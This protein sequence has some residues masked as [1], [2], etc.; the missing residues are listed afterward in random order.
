MHALLTQDNR[1]IPQQNNE[2]RPR[3]QKFTKKQ[4]TTNKSINKSNNSAKKSTGF[5]QTTR[6]S[7]KDEWEKALAAACD[8]NK[9]IFYNY[10]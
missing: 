10:F 3:S 8:S 4:T 9:I 6:N 7:T 5:R 2:F 1:L